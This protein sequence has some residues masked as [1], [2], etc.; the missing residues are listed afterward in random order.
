MAAD[1]AALLTLVLIGCGSF[2]A[3]GWAQ[4]FSDLQSAKLVGRDRLEIT[5][6]YSRVTDS[7][8]ISPAYPI[9]GAAGDYQGPAQH[10]F[11][12]QVATGVA[13]RVDLRGRY[14]RVEG[15][16]FV[17][18]GP[19]FELVKD[20]V[21]LAVPVGF[22]FGQGIESWR[23]WQAHPTL[24]FTAP[25]NRHVE[26]NA[27]GKVPFSFSGGNT[28]V[29]FNFG[30][31]FGDLDRWAIRPEVGFLFDPHQSGHHYTQ[32]SV[33]VTLFAGKKR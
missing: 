11:G 4:E 32:L 33:G 30:G 17:F 8:E 21:A 20:K 16:N 14:G 2:P 15:V 10:E 9:D 28:L 13:E 29:A 26:L 1:R 22:A 23:S 3:L 31:G 6:G 5:P 18:F 7:A 24:L 19:K 12:V 27:A 25:V